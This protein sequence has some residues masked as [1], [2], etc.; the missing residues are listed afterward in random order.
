M[1]FINNTVNITL[2]LLTPLHALLCL[3]AE[4]AQYWCSETHLTWASIGVEFPNN[5]TDSET[6]SGNRYCLNLQPNTGCHFP[7]TMLPYSSSR[8]LIPSLSLPGKFFGTTAI[9]YSFLS[10]WTSLNKM[11]SPLRLSLL[12][13]HLEQSCSV[14]R[15]SHVH[16]LK[17]VSARICTPMLCFFLQ[18]VNH[19]NS[20]LLML[21]FAP[22][23]QNPAA[24]EVQGSSVCLKAA[25]LQHPWHG[26]PGG[27]PL[28][29]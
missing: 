6:R 5:S 8:D 9:G 26:L 19:L 7:V 1:V 16:L 25:C 14:L 13:C 29:Q 21:H 17:K 10:A 18:Q 23:S 11:T 3:P 24:W 22:I 12:S 15:Y 27:K 20:R 2:H 4:S 28:W